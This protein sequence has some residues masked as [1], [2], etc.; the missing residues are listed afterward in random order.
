M[1]DDTPAPDAP[2]APPA[3]LSW[4]LK[5]APGGVGSL[6]VF[7]VLTYFGWNTERQVP[8]YAWV[9]AAGTFV[10]VRFFQKV[11]E[12]L[13]PDVVEGTANFVRTVPGRVG[14]VARGLVRRVTDRTES[15]Y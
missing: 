5:L 10:L 7:G 11:W 3:F 8:W 2:S 1:P 6:V 14:D 4:V 9:A 13:E 15:R 12:K